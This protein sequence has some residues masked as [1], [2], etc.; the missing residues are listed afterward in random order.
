MPGSTPYGSPRSRGS[1]Q[2][3]RASIC[4]IRPVSPRRVW[5]RVYTLVPEKFLMHGTDVYSCCPACLSRHHLGTQ[6]IYRVGTKGVLAPTKYRQDI[7]LSPGSI[8]KP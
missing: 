3:Q 4:M 2:A 8:D 7:A 5:I 6:G 1:K